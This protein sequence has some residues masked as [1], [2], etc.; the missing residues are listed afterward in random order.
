MTIRPVPIPF[1]E[2][3]C[4]V[5]EGFNSIGVQLTDLLGHFDDDLSFS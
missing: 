2:P 4:L 3:A 5:E 1:R